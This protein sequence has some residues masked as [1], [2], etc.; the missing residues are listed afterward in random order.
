M[1]NNLFNNHNL[2]IHSPLKSQNSFKSDKGIKQKNRK[3]EQKALTQEKDNSTPLKFDF[4]NQLQPS[5][6]FI[7]NDQIMRPQLPNLQMLYPQNSHLN[8]DQ[9]LDQSKSFLNNSKSLSQSV[10][11][12]L[13]ANCIR[14]CTQW[15]LTLCDQNK[16]SSMSKPKIRPLV[17]SQNSGVSL[18]QMNYIFEEGL[19]KE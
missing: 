11:H 5:S 19:T 9:S 14:K 8:G 17:V 15:Q 10:N 13:S 16:I 12:P 18:R 4:S 6:P 7:T 2:N 1:S 3:D